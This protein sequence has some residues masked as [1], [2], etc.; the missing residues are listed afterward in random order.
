[1]LPPSGAIFELKVHPNSY[2]AGASPR[3]PLGSLLSCQSPYLVFR[4]P[5]RGRGRDERGGERRKREGIALTHFLQF[6]ECSAVI[7]AASY[8]RSLDLALQLV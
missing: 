7:V 6:N 8:I 5:L 2:A 4:E 3:T 1:M